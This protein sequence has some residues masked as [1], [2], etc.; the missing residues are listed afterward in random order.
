MNDQTLGQRLKDDSKSTAANVT[1]AE[2]KKVAQV[3]DT[4]K[5]SG[6]NYEI[7]HKEFT[8]NADG[9]FRIQLSS[10]DI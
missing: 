6:R 1:W 10:R 2:L 8:E 9:T 3:G 7:T 4:V 5:E